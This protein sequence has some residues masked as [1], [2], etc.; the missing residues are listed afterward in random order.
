MKDINLFTA[1]QYV[2]NN[3]AIIKATNKFTQEE[4]EFYI[5][6]SNSELNDFFENIINFTLYF[7]D[8]DFYINSLTIRSNGK[9]NEIY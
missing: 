6:F 4:K 9:D 3:V 7:D 2:Y 8:M 1:G 5:P